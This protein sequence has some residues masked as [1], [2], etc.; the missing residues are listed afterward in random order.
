MTLSIIALSI[1]IISFL[2]TVVLI[3]NERNFQSEIRDSFKGMRHVKNDI[4]NH[5]KTIQSLIDKHN[6][7][8]EQKEL[9]TRQKHWK[10]FNKWK[11]QKDMSEQQVGQEPICIECYNEGLEL[12]VNY[13]SDPDELYYKTN[14]DIGF[15][16]YKNNYPLSAEQK[17][18]VCGHINDK[19]KY[20]E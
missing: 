11:M 5:Y 10:S 8:Q 16:G 2:G 7:E 1:S 9:E 13:K 12:D 3:S 19:W 18:T 15:I 4:D 17:C 14:G 20:E 6:K